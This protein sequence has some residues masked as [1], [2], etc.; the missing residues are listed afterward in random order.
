MGVR[1]PEQVQEGV[2][3]AVAGLQEVAG[4]GEDALAQ[5]GV[6]VADEA[7]LRPCQ[8]PGG[9]GRIRI[10]EGLG[11][12]RAAGGQAPQPGQGVVAEGAVGVVQ[13]P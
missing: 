4:A 6:V 9:V 3:A 1:Q 8:R 7:L 2:G 5:G 13:L 12:R 11:Q 10:E